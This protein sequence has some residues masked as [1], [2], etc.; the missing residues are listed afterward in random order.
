MEFESETTVIW[1]K[2]PENFKISKLSASWISQI[3]IRWKNN[4]KELDSFEKW[5]SDAHYVLE[6]SNRLFSSKIL[7]F[8]ITI[9]FTNGSKQFFRWKSLYWIFG[10][11]G[12]ATSSK[13]QLS[14]I[15]QRNHKPVNTGEGDQH[16]R[17]FRTIIL[18]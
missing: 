10:N 15:N 18:R 2:F 11:A 4:Q 7:I 3:K 13:L 14:K 9:G 8:L 12:K 17:N 5:F 16:L 1:I 6:R